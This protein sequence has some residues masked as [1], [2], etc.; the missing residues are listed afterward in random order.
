[1]KIF[2]YYPLKRGTFKPQYFGKLSAA[3]SYQLL[4]RGG[5][6]QLIIRVCG[7]SILVGVGDNPPLTP[8]RRGRQETGE[9]GREREGSSKNCQFGI[10]LPNY[11][12]KIRSFLRV[13]D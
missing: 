2:I 8:P 5:V 13:L 4:I 9:M 10:F 6:Q 3:I 1:M 7:K 12:P 11:A